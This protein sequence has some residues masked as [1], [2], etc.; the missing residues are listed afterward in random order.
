MAQFNW[1]IFY[2]CRFHLDHLKIFL[3]MG[4]GKHTITEDRRIITKMHENGK[5]VSEIAKD[6]PF[7]RKKVYNAI[8]SCVENP[9]VLIKGKS[10][11]PR[12]R[13]TNLRTDAAM[14]RMAKIDPFKSS[15]Q[16]SPDINESFD[17]EISSRLGKFIWALFQEKTIVLKKK[18]FKTFSLRQ[19]P[20]GQ[21][22]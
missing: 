11:K 21:S 19:N 8:K 18:C 6:L 12:P 9:D 22:Y 3:Y 1:N 20:Y 14:V 13:K 4:S 7:S 15:R 17:L 5:K 16:I 10:R 2:T